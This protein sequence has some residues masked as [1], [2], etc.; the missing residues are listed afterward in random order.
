MKIIHAKAN[1]LRE[2]VANT[3]HAVCDFDHTIASTSVFHRNSVRIAALMCGVVIS[4]DTMG[5]LKG[6]TEPQI[7]AILNSEY[8][9]SE[10][11]FIIARKTALIEA[12]NAELESNRGSLPWRPT[13]WC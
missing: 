4:E 11:R 7:A 3:G 9:I 1:T 8:G 6:H 12:V 13:A 2:I 10:E 5:S